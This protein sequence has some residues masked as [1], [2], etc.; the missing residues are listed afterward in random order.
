MSCVM[1]IPF[2]GVS[3]QVQHKSGCIATEDVER[4]YKV[5][6]LCYI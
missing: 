1:K 4:I 6:G 5:E 2:F 3:S